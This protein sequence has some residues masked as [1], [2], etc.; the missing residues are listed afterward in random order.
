MQLSRLFAQW[1]HSF[2]PDQ[3]NN[4]SFQETSRRLEKVP[5]ET[6]IAIKKKSKKK[7]S[8]DREI[9]GEPGGRRKRKWTKKGADAIF[10]MP[11]WPP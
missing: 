3:K 6:E 8:S 10:A 11:R 9:W 5:N 1:A 2:K 7:R 4:E